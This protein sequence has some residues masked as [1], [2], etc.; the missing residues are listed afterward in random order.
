MEKTDL[1]IVTPLYNAADTLPE[2]LSSVQA[3]SNQVRLEHII[4]NNMSDDGS[5]ELVRSYRQEAKY[6]VREIKEPDGGIYEAMNKGIQISDGASILILNA[7]DIVAVNGTV[8]Q[9]HLLTQGCDLVGG[10]VT[11]FSGKQNVAE[12]IRQAG[13]KDWHPN[14]KGFLE[15]TSFRPPFSHVGMVA[16]RTCYEAIGN[17]DCSYRV[18][19]DVD[20][21]FRA[22]GAGLKF[23]AVNTVVGYFRAGGRSS[24]GS[25]IREYYQ[26][27]RRHDE[28]SIRCKAFIFRVYLNHFLR[29]VIKS[30][31]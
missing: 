18:A 3:L 10:I 30:V 4:I 14:L 11:K 2:A 17:Y 29:S 7:D 21:M 12:G 22:R 19:A 15:G 23:G 1:S 27:L 25:W 6:K 5:S 24:N 20:W 16:K 31:Y 9:L 28:S 26:L 13:T 8:G